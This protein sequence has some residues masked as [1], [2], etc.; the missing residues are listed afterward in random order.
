MCI[1]WTKVI[2]F[3]CNCYIY[4]IYMHTYSNWYYQVKSILWFKEI[5]IRQLA[6]VSVNWNCAL[7]TGYSSV[8]NE[9]HTERNTFLR[10]VL[11]AVSAYINQYRQDFGH[12]WELMC[13]NCRC[14]WRKRMCMQTMKV[15]MLMT[16][17]LVICVI[18]VRRTLSSAISDVSGLE[19]R[20]V[21]AGANRA[22]GLC[23]N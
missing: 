16:R 14:I 18:S 10:Q 15:I 17:V 23:R 6:C 21:F 7:C 1:C 3:R 13:L 20:P 12:A 4:H 22:F 19:I 8:W 11:R 2:K 9:K 5:K